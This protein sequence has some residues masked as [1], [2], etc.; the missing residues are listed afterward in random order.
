MLFRSSLWEP[1]SALAFGA[2]GGG[3]KRHT[4]A[5]A[6]A[7]TGLPRDRVVYVG[8]N[9]NDVDAGLFNGVHFIGFAADPAHRRR[10]AAAGARHTASNHDETGALI[11]A[12]LAPA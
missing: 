12:F 10:L 6:I 5:R 8:D 1:V 4:V 2:E 9:L 7:A 3:A 11:A